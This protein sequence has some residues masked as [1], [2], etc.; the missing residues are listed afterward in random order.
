MQ[1]DFEWDISY[2]F[3]I[4]V[5]TQKLREIEGSLRHL[6]ERATKR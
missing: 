5:R 1:K 3:R 2:Y 4:S 6:Y